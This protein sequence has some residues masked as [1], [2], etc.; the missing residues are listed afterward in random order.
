[1]RRRALGDDTCD[2]TTTSCPDQPP[3]PTPTPSP[4]TPQ[5]CGE[6][7]E[8]SEA[9]QTCVATVP[10][11]P[12]AWGYAWDDASQECVP[13]PTTEPDPNAPPVTPVTPKKATPAAPVVVPVVPTPTL[14]TRLAG[15]FSGPTGWIIGGVVVLGLVFGVAAE[16]RKR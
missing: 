6:G 11:D 14:S 12:C 1:M 3:E 4:L 15:M 2:P 7:Y 9:A 5:I 8:W 13:V 16:S 10:S